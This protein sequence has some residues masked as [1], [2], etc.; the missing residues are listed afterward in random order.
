MRTSIDE[1]KRLLKHLVSIDDDYHFLLINRH[2]TYLMLSNFTRGK[3]VLENNR[4]RLM[5]W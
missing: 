3:K 1:F 2:C 4:G 5:K